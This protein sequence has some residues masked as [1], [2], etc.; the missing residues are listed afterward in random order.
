[1]T[2]Q[3]WGAPERNKE[4]ILD[5]L[6]KV[7]PN[8][9]TLLELA[10]GS[11]QHAAYFAAQFPRLNIQPSDVDPENL[12]SVRAWV[13]EAALPNLLAPISLDVREANWVPAPVNAIFSANLLHI[14]AWECSVALFDG[15]ARHLA[16]EGVLVVYGPFRV[17]GQHTAPSNA[18]FDES[19]K[20]RNPDW[21]VRDVEAL[22]ALAAPRGLV[23]TQRVLMPANNQCLI[24]HRANV[25]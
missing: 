16:A 23:A 8:D 22:H 17:D 6:R 1:M 10:S 21:G 19:L 20:A 12:A 2:K 4:P 9:G 11:G 5:V 25:A 13:L 15:A 7:L 24:F 18:A 3:V 14:S